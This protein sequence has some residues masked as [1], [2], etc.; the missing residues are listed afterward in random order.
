[1]VAFLEIQIDHKTCIGKASASSFGP[2]DH[3]LKACSRSAPSQCPSSVE[4]FPIALHISFEL[5]QWIIK[6]VTISSASSQ[7]GHLPGLP[8]F[9]F[10]GYPMWGWNCLVLTMQDNCLWHGLYFPNLFPPLRRLPCRLGSE[11]CS[12][13]QFDWVSALDRIG[14]PK[15]R[16][17]FLPQLYSCLLQ[18]SSEYSPLLL[19]F[20]QWGSWL[21]CWAVL[22]SD[23]PVGWP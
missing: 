19:F 18:L 6:W 11:Q 3:W 20:P 8:S 13:P 7:R 1:M 17:F 4:R 23:L 21:S 9:I 14:A 16:V 15:E 10:V 22:A 2:V 5:W 12:I